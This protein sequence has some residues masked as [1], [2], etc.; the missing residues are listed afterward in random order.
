MKSNLYRFLTI[1]VVLAFFMTS[2]NL[3]GSGTANPAVPLVSTSKSLLPELLP[4][5]FTDLLEAKVASGEWTLE[6]GLVT[7][8]KLFAGEIQASDAGL[9]DGVQESEGTGIAQMATEYLETGT[10]EAAKTEITRLLSLIVPSQAMLDPYTTPQASSIRAPGLAGPARLADP[11]ECANLWAT[12]FPDTRTPSFQCFL[13]GQRDI[14]G[15]SYRVYYPL[16][17]EGD[18]SKTPYYDATLQAIEDTIP[19]YQGYGTVK[20]IYFVFTTLADPNNPASFLAVTSWSSFQ[21][22]S[23]ACPVIVYPLALTLSIPVF[24]Q[25]MAHEM[26][27]CFQ[28][29]SLHAQLIDAGYGSSKWWAEGAAEYFSNVVYPSTDYEYRFANSFSTRSTGESLTAMSYE[30]FAFFQ[31]VADRFGGPNAVLAILQALPTTPGIAEQIAA[32]AAYPNMDGMFEQFAQVF[33]DR[34]LMDTSGETISFPERYSATNTV[35]GTV[36]LSYGAEP[37]VLRRFAINF[38]PKKHFGTTTTSSGAGHD[39]AHIRGVTGGWAPIPADLNS[40]CGGTPYVLYVVNTQPG[41]ERDYTLES[42]LIGDAPCDECLIGSWQGTTDSYMSY[43]QSVLG[44]VGE[45]TFDSISGGVFADFQDTGLG[46][47]EYQNFVVQYTVHTSTVPGSPLDIQFTM[48]FNGLSS[49][50]WTADGTNLAFSGQEGG[51]DYTLQATANGQ[52]MDLGGNSMPDIPTSP[53]GDGH[54]TCSGDTFSYWPPYPG[55]TVSP[56]VYQR[57]SP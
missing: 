23:E 10:D 33:L 40:G 34:Q 3:L 47:G 44:S 37:F 49:G 7:M 57:R 32:L 31:F 13:S 22:D 27:H 51:I 19:V 48:T 12:G 35:S 24:K 29:W 9:G 41:D 4:A 8:L 39:A 30:N 53:I 17:W 25:S 50:M 14:G 54:Y 56:I 15:S 52:S 43:L 21:P 36:A 45:V 42:T 2:C 18:A 6:E 16:A 1:S 20:S 26:F 55:A 46:A 5:G 11:Q 38:A 28:D